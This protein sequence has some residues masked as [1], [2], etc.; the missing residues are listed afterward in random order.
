MSIFKLNK[1]LIAD[2]EIF[3]KKKSEKISSKRI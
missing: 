1:I 2:K 3:L